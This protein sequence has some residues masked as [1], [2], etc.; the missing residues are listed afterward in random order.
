MLNNEKILFIH[1]GR[2]L[3][4]APVSLLNTIKGLEKLG[5]K[6]IKILFAYDDMKPFFRNNCSAEIGDVYNPCLY[7]GRLAIG[8]SRM[9]K[10]RLLGE[11]FLLPLSIYK[12]YRIFK[13]EKPSIIH[14][15]SSILFSSAIAARLAG[16]K[17]VWHIREI[18]L[19]R[20]YPLLVRFY[21]WLVRKL[22]DN[23][24]AISY[25]E[26]KSIGLRSDKN[27]EVVYNFIDFNKFNYRNH[28]QIEQKRKLGFK[29][30]DKIVLYISNVS[31]R[32]GTLE[33]IQSLS[34]LKDNVFIVAVG[35]EKE[36]LFKKPDSD[37]NSYR[38]KVVREL[39]KVDDSK[40]FFA[41]FQE[42]VVGYISASDLLVA[43][44]TSPHFA[45][46]I[47]EA[48]S[49]KKPVIAF[50]IAGISENVEDGKN[51]ILVKTM[52]GKA[53]ADAINDVIFNNEKLEELGENGYK[54]ACKDFRQDIN[55]KKIYDIY[56]NLIQ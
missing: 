51:C 26:A 13:K 55:V 31:K 45:R 6:N 33:L 25:A 4:G 48:W 29:K 19:K 36:E 30:D 54:K 39:K 23:V 24:I 16:C 1:H 18:F 20:D 53:L 3:G 44:W 47:F 17:L 12:Q 9:N 40:I 41:G 46:P 21:G 37:F 7:L 10:K 49:M 14:L 2:V 27:V 42:D 34:S 22:A 28:N 56:D 11:I 8:W 35:I 52:T 50:D 38:N 43:P 15:N 5:C 32:K